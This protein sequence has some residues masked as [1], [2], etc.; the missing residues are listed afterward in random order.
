MIIDA[1]A[2]WK[3][4]DKKGTSYLSGDIK[5][6]E[7]QKVS[8]LIYKNDKKT[9]EKQPDYRVFTLVEDAPKEEPTSEQEDINSPF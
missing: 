6:S 3:K 2:L 8:V 1:G 4:T 5:V 9:A 7:T